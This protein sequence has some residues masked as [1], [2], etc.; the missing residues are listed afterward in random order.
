MSLSQVPLCRCLFNVFSVSSL[1][2]QYSI[3]SLSPLK[4]LLS[5]LLTT[6]ILSPS[7]LSRFLHYPHH[8]LLAFTFLPTL[9]KNFH[10]QHHNITFLHLHHHHFSPFLLFHHHYQHHQASATSPNYTTNLNMYVPYNLSNPLAI[11]NNFGTNLH[12]ERPRIY[13]FLYIP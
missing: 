12:R 10:H 11:L 4:L 6:P 7:P 8:Y 2:P 13:V 3:P 1:Q 9:S 5:F